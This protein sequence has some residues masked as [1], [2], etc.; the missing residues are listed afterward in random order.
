LYKELE[1][2]APNKKNLNK[3]AENVRQ[4][5]L[6]SIGTSEGMMKLFDEAKN[7]FKTNIKALD[8]Q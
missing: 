4:I 6:K 3:N 7:E 8:W 5:N 1:K 2:R